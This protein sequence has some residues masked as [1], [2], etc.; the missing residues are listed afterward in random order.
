MKN[1][2]KKICVKIAVFA[3]IILCTG[4]QQ[5]NEQQ[6]ERMPQHTLSELREEAENIK[7]DYPNIDFSETEIIIPEG[8]A[9]EELIF[10]VKVDISESGENFEEVK[11]MF[12]ENI[13][14]LT[15]GEE[16]NEDYVCYKVQQDEKPV[17]IC[18][19]SASDRKRSKHTETDEVVG[20][21][22]LSYNDSVH[23]ML[24]Y[25]SSFML[26]LAGRSVS[27]HSD[28]KYDWVGHRPPEGVVVKSFEL[29]GDSI[30]NV[31]YPLDGEEVSLKDAV[32]YV[33][34]NMG[35]GYHFVRSP[36]LDYQVCHV[37]VIEFKEGAYYYDMKVRALYRGISF[38][39]AQYADVSVREEEEVPYQN[40]SVTH[41]AVMMSGE[42]ID[43]VWSSAHSYE[44][45]GE[46]EVYD[47]FLSIHEA[48]QILSDEVSASVGLKCDTVELMYRTEF[49]YDSSGV[50]VK[51]VRC[52]P[53]YQFAFTDT[54]LPED[55]VLYFNVDAVSGRVEGRQA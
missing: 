47:R 39:Y 48:M 19:V 13:K 20:G 31:K 23:S 37:D 54:G 14:K 53:V 9:I 12:Y 33:E 16:V 52:H 22:Y 15:G 30:E 29:P 50:F 32:A 45:K 18:E 2:T 3:G 35:K 24:L 38:S 5:E 25:G 10:P 6:K 40:V 41:E 17:P 11:Q 36:Y 55:P 8:D 7:A 51:E 28:K 42:C 1:Q 49:Y 34:E 26:E 4:C 27:E 44:E 46:G 43:Y 21:Y